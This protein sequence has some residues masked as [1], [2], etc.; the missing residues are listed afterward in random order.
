[1]RAYN[2]LRAA[3]WYRRQA[4]DEGL[5]RAGY[6]VF[7]G[8]PTSSARGD[9]LLVWNR[10]GNSHEQASRFE[11]GG[12]TVLVCENGYLNGDGGSP[13]FAVHPRGPKPTD[14]YAIG[15]GFHNDAGRVPAGGPERWTA[16][17][18]SLKPWRQDGGHILVCANRSF[19]VA[20]R[21]MPQDWAVRTAERLKKI[22][23]RP[24]R[25]RLHP[26]NDAPRTPLQRDLEGAWAMVIW[27]S[28]SGVHAL[29]EGIP[30]FCL[31]PY[32]IAKGATCADLGLVDTPPLPDRLPALQRMAWGQ[33]Q[34]QE[35]EAGMAF[36]LLLR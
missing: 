13:K 33:W 23:K 18:V 14:Y 15:M 26:G 11:R 8:P 3:P 30:V 34:L 28:S 31:A 24:V 29:V 16:L 7:P 6:E 25:V 5:K 17:G 12:G 27:S 10:Y 9:L 2:C 19:G 35:V 36:R 1:M 20:E 32:W 21:V 22:T 4:F